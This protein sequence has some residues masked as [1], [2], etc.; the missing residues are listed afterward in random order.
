MD[1][2]EETDA[3]AAKR[4]DEGLDI[5]NDEREVAQARGIGLAEAVGARGGRVFVL[6]E[7]DARAGDGGI[8]VSEFGLNTGEADDGVDPRAGNDAALGET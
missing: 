8:Q 2:A 1:S 5:G 7:F 3:A 6:D 4:G